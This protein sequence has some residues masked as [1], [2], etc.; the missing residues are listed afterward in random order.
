MP[1]KQHEETMD[2]TQDQVHFT[3]Q[4]K[5]GV[6]KS[7]TASVQAQ[8]FSKKHG[9][10]KLHCFDTDP[11]NDTFTQYKSFDVQRVNI[12]SKDL[13]I[14]S[15]GFDSLM[16]KLLSVKGISVVDNGASTFVPLMAY[17]VENSVMQL[18]RDAGKKVFVHTVVTGGQ[19]LDDTVYGLSKMLQAHP[20]PIVVWLNEYF[21]DIQKDG[22]EFEQ[23]AIYLE[24]KDRILGLVRI[25]RRN[26]DTFGKDMEIMVSSKMT[27]EEAIEGQAFDVLPKHRLATMRD[28]LFAQLDS[29]RF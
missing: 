25:P 24:N 7:F 13:N 14:N 15:R 5:G 28:A 20:A 8:Y 1:G 4:G 18:L 11:V 3:M 19:A 26:Q 22:K 17:I 10:D 6:G 16:E 21:G 12:L 23:S 9:L 2:K 27:F 29:I